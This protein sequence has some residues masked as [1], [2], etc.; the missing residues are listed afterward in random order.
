MTKDTASE[1]RKG[2]VDSIAGKAKEVAGA[3]LGRDDLVTEGR[4][5]HDSA[6]AER[7]AAVKEEAAHAEAKQAAERIAAEHR[8]AEAPRAAALGAPTIATAG[9]GL[10][11]T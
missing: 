2:L 7:D 4:A 6:Q 3:V 9:H 1:A 11:C 5:Q 8:R 10:S